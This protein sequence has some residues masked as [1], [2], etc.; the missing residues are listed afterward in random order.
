KFS[1]APMTVISNAAKFVA[2]LDPRKHV[3]SNCDRLLV[4][5]ADLGW[6][7]QPMLQMLTAAEL[8]HFLCFLS[9]SPRLLVPFSPCRP[10]PLSH[11]PFHFFG[12]IPLKKQ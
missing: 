5:S 1:L 11:L 10:Y 12:G 9:S 3:I 2:D 6:R 7:N 8:R 4:S